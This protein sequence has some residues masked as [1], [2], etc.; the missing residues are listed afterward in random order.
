[1]YPPTHALR[2]ITKKFNFHSRV[3]Q[4][5]QM[6]VVRKEGKLHDKYN[7]FRSAFELLESVGREP[8]DCFD[9]TNEDLPPLEELKKRMQQM[10]QKMHQQEQKIQQQMQQ[11]EQ[12]MQ[13]MQHQ[14]QM[15]QQMQQQLNDLK[16]RV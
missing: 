12:M 11:Q 13:Q 4:H 1:M 6:L 16:S 15:M 9:E 14:E 3:C 8:R 2:T 10:Q 7:S 5:A